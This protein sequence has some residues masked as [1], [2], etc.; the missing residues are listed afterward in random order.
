[1]SQFPSSSALTIS[2]ACGGRPGRSGR[3]AVTIR[4]DWSADTG[5][6]L[7]LERIAAAFG[8]TIACLDLTER[9][10][11]CVR[12]VWL[13]RQRLVP[14]GIRRTPQGRWGATAP[15]P[16]CDCAVVSGFWKTPEEAAA[17]LRTLR[18]W[19]RAFGADTAA[20][21]RLIV[22]IER[23][24]GTV[25]DAEPPR[26]A[27]ST[28][29]D[30]HTDLAWLWEV[31][32]HP[33]EVERMHAG[34]GLAR[35]MAAIGYLHVAT[36]GAA[37]EDLV[38]YARD[39]PQAVS[40]AASTW[41]PHDRAAPAERFEWYL[42][43]LHWRG[44]SSLLGGPYQLADVQALADATGKSRNGA[45]AVL[46]G[47]LDAGCCPTFE[48]VLTVCRLVPGGR[49]SPP[50]GALDLVQR[51]AGDK[52]TRTQAGLILVAAGTPTTATSLIRRGVRTLADLAP[53]TTPEPVEGSP[54]RGFD[55][56]GQRPPHDP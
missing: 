35:P 18:H 38:P 25:F 30:H 12:Q 47:W 26:G 15:A 45:A 46:A 49:Q 48:E 31:G 53:P 51:M 14:P 41:R 56:L 6:D 2:V 29:V 9:R 16:D 55:K 43:G 21:N 24:A 27:R 40:W 11:P 34:L 28:A 54:R 4:P 32:V 17:H 52:L 44:I 50:V 37:L 33:D 10:L 23:A 3:H 1:M 36:C 42:S 20:C 39:S 7:E 5:H 13:H 8:S 19:A 22:A